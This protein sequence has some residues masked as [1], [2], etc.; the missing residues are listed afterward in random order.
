MR[1]D[2]LD[3]VGEL[4]WSDDVAIQGTLDGFFRGL[5]LK[6]ED[7]IISESFISFFQSYLS[8]CEKVDLYDLLQTVADRYNQDAPEIH[9]IKENLETHATVLHNAITNI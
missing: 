3:G 6:A 9:L 2:R 5:A 4:V 7:G 8:R 1:L